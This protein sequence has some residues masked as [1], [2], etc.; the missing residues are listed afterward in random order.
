MSE[1]L[2]VPPHLGIN[3]HELQTSRVLFLKSRSITDSD[4]AAIA[5]FLKQN[6]ALTQLFIGY[7]DFGDDGT[8]HLCE[9]LAAIEG[10]E[11]TVYEVL[12]PAW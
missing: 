10:T 8:R 1:D 3:A 12:R 11:R 7:N 9:A 2:A 4:C 6:T 5:P